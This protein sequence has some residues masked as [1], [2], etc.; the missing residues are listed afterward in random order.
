MASENKRASARS[1]KASKPANKKASTKKALS[2]AEPKWP[3]PKPAATK[4]MA[5]SKILVLVATRKGAWFY[6]SDAARKKWRKLCVD[7]AVK[8]RCHFADGADA[9][10]G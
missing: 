5:T 2:N 3:K 6:R 7:E 1:R 8:T 10:L 9:V 4:R